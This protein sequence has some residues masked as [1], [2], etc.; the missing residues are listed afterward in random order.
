AGSA[1]AGPRESR[2]AQFGPIRNRS[3]LLR[4]RNPVSAH[5]W[6]QWGLFG[7][8]LFFLCLIVGQYAGRRMEER[9][10][11]RTPQRAF[12][13]ATTRLK[14]AQQYLD[15]RNPRAFYGEVEAALRQVVEARLAEPT[16]SMTRSDLRNR[17]GNLG[18]PAELIN[19]VVEEL[20]T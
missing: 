7:P 14:Q 16:G 4:V 3:R 19:R 17:L 13:G 10:A 6:Y 2:D 20:D 15:A 12:R 1:V 18:A 8:P 5:A 11:E 9:S